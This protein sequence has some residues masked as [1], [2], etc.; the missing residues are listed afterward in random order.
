MK[1]KLIFL[2]AFFV[3]VQSFLGCD[4]IYGI[5][6][7][8]A[9]E[10]KALIGEMN[11]FMYNEKVEQIQKFLKVNGYSCGKIDGKM[12]PKVREAIVKFQEDRGLTAN[13]YVDQET[14]KELNFFVNL[15]LV[16]DGE[17]NVAFVQEILSKEGFNPGKIDGKFGPK[18]ILAIKKLQETNGLKTDGKI[19]PKTLSILAD[20]VMTAEY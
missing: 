5:I 4:F 2:L 14:W 19:G 7:R 13:R 9:A 3:C 12:G 18:T 6:Q 10:E 20:Y 11:P 15:G 16:F 1:R 8:E 17:V